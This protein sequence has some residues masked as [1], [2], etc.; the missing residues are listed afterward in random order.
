MTEVRSESLA[1]PRFLMALLLGLSGTAILLA[2]V[3]IHGLVA[4]SVAER[5]REMGIRLA[6]G[7]TSAQAVRT[8]ALPGIVLTA[9]G[10]AIGFAGATAAGSLLRHFI[11]GV[12]TTDPLTFVAVAALFL[13]VA[14]I[15]SLVPSMRLL[16]LDPAT[17]LRS[18]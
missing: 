14:T 4:A 5:T 6:V 13:G 18:E 15:A 1:L 3:G 16:R 11:W 7:A 9:A 2:G 12:R 8:L 10:V 17:T